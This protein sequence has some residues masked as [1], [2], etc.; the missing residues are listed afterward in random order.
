MAI[1][2]YYYITILQSDNYYNKTILHYYYMA[3]FQYNK[4]TP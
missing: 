3:I 4:I 1:L 2:Q